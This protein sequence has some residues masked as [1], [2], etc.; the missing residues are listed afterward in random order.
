MARSA[1]Q[2]SAELLPSPADRNSL[3]ED[4]LRLL[5]EAVPLVLPTVSPPPLSV[6]EA[7]VVSIL[8]AVVSP[9]DFGAELMPDV[10][11]AAAR[12]PPLVAVGCGHRQ[13]RKITNLG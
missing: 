7:C 2:C 13:D 10:A 6:R 9:S 5:G 3:A 4:W 8:I 1:S 11:A 12:T